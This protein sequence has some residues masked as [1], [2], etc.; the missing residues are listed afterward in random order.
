MEEIKTI[1]KQEIPNLE[2]KISGGD[3]MMHLSHRN[4]QDCNEII[5][6]TKKKSHKIFT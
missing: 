6:I 1:M 3:V 5:G 4:L 2:K